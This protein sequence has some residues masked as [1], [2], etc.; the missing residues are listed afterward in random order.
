M[1]VKSKKDEPL[2]HPEAYRFDVQLDPGEEAKYGAE[3]R[4]REEWFDKPGEPPT[5]LRDRTGHIVA[6]WLDGRRAT[7]RICVPGWSG[8]R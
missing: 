7:V 6:A 1:K 3:I 8:P 2:C 4:I 5:E